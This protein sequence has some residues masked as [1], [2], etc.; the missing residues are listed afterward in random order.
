MTDPSSLPPSGSLLPDATMHPRHVAA[1][2]L[3]Q[4]TFWLNN[5]QLWFA[6]VEATFD[7]HHISSEV[8][9]FRH[10]LCNLSPDVA[11]EVADVIA[12]PLH[13]A[14][15]QCLKQSI[16]DRTTTSESERLRHLLTSEE[17]GE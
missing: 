17:L 4:P 9:R 12:A 8:P 14:Q 3:R 5:P 13:D 6:Q 10:L 15:Y 11:Q 2:Q 7:L 1:L 16:L